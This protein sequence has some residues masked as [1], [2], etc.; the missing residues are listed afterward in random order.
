MAASGV[1]RLVLVPSLLQALLA[2][3]PTLAAQLPRLNH[4]V[5]SGERLTTS[6]MQRF[7]QLLPAAQLLNLYGSSEVAGDATWY[8]V[9]RTTVA[10]HDAWAS[11]PIGRPYANVQVYILDAYR[12]LVPIGI[13]GELYIGGAGLARG[14][15]NQPALTAEKFVANP[16]GSDRLYR[17]GDRGRWLP[18]PR[19]TPTIEY[20]GRLDHQVKLRGFRIELGEIETILN[21]HPG[22]QEAVVLARKDQPGEKQ[23]VAY[24]VAD[25]EIGQDEV[26]S[27]P[28]PSLFLS[29]LRSFLRQKLPD[30]MIPAAFVLLDALPVTPNGKVDRMALPPPAADRANLTAAYEAPQ[31]ALEQ[32]LT[33]LWQQQLG[34]ERI[35]RYDNF[36]ELGGDSIRAAMLINQLQTTLQEVFYVVALFDAP[37]IAQF[38]LYL[39]RYYTNAVAR[40]LGQT[41]PNA[42]SPGVAPT[43]DANLVQQFRTLIKPLPCGRPATKKNPPAIFVLS[44]PRSGSTLLRVMLGG[45]PRLFAPPE[46]HLLSC[47]TLAEREE[48]FAGRF[49]FCLEGLLRAIMELQGVSVETAKHIVADASSEKQTTPE[50]YRRLQGW[51]GENR[52]LVDKTPAYALD[53]ETLRRAERDFDQPYYIHLVRHPAAM[54]TSFEEAHT[55]QIFFRYPHAFSAHSLAELIWLVSHQNILD[56]LHD[57][58]GERQFRLPF[59]T[60]VKQPRVI[61]DELC[62][63]LGLEFVETM[64]QPYQGKAQRMTDGLYAVSKMLG[65]AKFHNYQ[66]IEPAVADR[67]QGR[68]PS[69]FLG[70]PT[71]QLAERFG[72]VR[73]MQPSQQNIQPISRTVYRMQR[74]ADGTLIKPDRTRE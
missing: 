16:F 25:K 46:L 56:F 27:A 36:L 71:W 59:E 33:Q 40:L 53:L 42:A 19:G 57:V 73:P 34:I 1:T 29:G 60:L 12:Q 7:H 49:S 64:V 18:R 58:P 50:F 10:H 20:L 15:H 14:Y 70:Q 47:N 26:S 37:T 11:V 22:V 54:I 4:W 30:Y 13:P 55:D 63:W 41:M 62:Q 67:W 35:G 52:M 72:Y 69:D 74:G 51:I 48:V 45:H 17:T 66:Q 21:G 65:D 44:S 38:A 61:V 39:Q 24:I 32:W 23:L 43:I 2:T 68:Y 3:T 6:L 9:A 5:C 31:G 28:L 8:D